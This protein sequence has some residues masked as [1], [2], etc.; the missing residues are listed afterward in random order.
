M[1]RQIFLAIF[2]LT[3]FCVLPVF[4]QSEK[5]EAK[6]VS[7]EE[8]QAVCRADY[9]GK[10]IDLNIVN[11]GINDFM[12]YIADELGFSYVIDRSVERKPFSMSIEDRPWNLALGEI[13]QTQGLTIQCR[14][15]YLLI[16]K[17]KTK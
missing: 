16:T 4:A 17:K 8:Y 9:A 3:I 1:K 6:P 12:N 5:S 15:Q 2:F 10:K 14:E 7:K 11:A 13:L